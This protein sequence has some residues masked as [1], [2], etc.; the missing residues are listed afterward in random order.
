MTKTLEIPSYV[1][2]KGSL[3]ANKCK[4]VA[5]MGQ[6]RAAELSLSRPERTKENSNGSSD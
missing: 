2:T 1:L 3:V 4:I 5:E 6:G